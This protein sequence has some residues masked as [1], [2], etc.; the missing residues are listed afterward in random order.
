MQAESNILNQLRKIE[1][2]VSGKA[3]QQSLQNEFLPTLE[4]EYGFDVYAEIVYQLTRLQVPAH[5]AQKYVQGVI[6]HMLSMS[7][8]LG[9]DIGFCV[10][11]CD[12]FVNVAKVI[13][14]PVLMEEHY[15]RQK[16]DH[17]DRDGL[18]GLANRAC[19]DREMAREIEK[20]K[21]LGTP[22]SLLM[23]D[24]DC[25]KDIN[26]MYGH[27][28]G[29]EV[30]RIMAG[31]FTQIARAYDSVIRYGGDEFAV[32]LPHTNRR[33]ATAVA[34]RLRNS[35]EKHRF[36][37]DGAELE[38]VTV[39]VGIATYPI[40]SL[41]RFGMVRMADQALYVAKRQKNCAVAYCDYIRPNSGFDLT[42]RRAP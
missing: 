38:Q 26:D 6:T 30:L 12:Y 29:D 25:F 9:R 28:A 42:E 35:I 33:D 3:R 15:L 27:L 39:S 22:F 19:F 20:F 41:D 5:V 7:S 37:V 1:E 13:K 17:A 18:T 21:R 8:S 11:S 32:L 24:V 40:D 31:I 14:E 23:I 16:E 36:L 34:E 2:G 10:A 4:R